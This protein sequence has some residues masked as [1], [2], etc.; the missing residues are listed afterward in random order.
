MIRHETSSSIILS[1]WQRRPIVG[2][3]RECGKPRL[4]PR[5][6]CRNNMPASIR[7]SSENGGVL[8]C[9][10]SQTRGLSLLLICLLYVTF[11]ILSIGKDMKHFGLNRGERRLRDRV[12]ASSPIAA[13]GRRRP[14]YCPRYPR[15]R[16][17]LSHLLPV[18]QIRLLDNSIN[19]GII[20]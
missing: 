5:C 14:F 19:N 8:I 11:D 6:S 18:L 12:S 9:P 7:A 10:F 2:I 4:L 16:D 20:H 15:Q 3:G 13:C 17:P 1:S